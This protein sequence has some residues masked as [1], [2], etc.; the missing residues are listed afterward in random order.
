VTVTR[1]RDQMGRQQVIDGAVW[2]AD[3]PDSWRDAAVYRAGQKHMT[4][5][6]K[7]RTKISFQVL[8]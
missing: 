3:V 1:T 4:R 5:E 2:Q 7:G 8:D 6:T